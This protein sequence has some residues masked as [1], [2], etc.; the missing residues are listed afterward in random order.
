MEPYVLAPYFRCNIHAGSYYVGL[1]SKQTKI[2]NSDDFKAIMLVASDF[3]SERL[4]SDVMHSSA[5]SQLSTNE[6]ER[7]ISFLKEQ[8]LIFPSKR[9]DTDSV[10]SRQKLYYEYMGMDGAEVIENLQKSHICILGAGGIGNHAAFGLAAAGVG[11]LTVID[12]DDIEES[13]LTRQFLFGLED[14]GTPKVEALQREIQRRFPRTQIDVQNHY[15]DEYLNGVPDC[16]FLFVAADTP[17][18]I[19]Q[20]VARFCI[21]KRLPYI[22][23]VTV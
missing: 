21:A 2:T 17:R 20:N 12:G 1:G 11:R 4:I 22:G 7:A 6:K 5:I 23:L 9:R 19:M 13:N 8:N 18:D 15:V 3:K 16:D 10:Y 14:I